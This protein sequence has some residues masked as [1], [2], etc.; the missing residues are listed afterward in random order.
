MDREDIADNLV[1]KCKTDPGAPIEVS[2]N[3]V[4][5]IEDVYKLALDEDDETAINSEG[6]L[7][8]PAYDGYL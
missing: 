4:A 5:K 7:R 6:A 8:S 1:R 3:L 2:I